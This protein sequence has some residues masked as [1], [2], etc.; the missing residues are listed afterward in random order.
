MKDSIVDRLLAKRI[1]TIDGEINGDKVIYIKK[2]L[3]NLLLQGSPPVKV[4]IS[5]NGGKVMAGLDIYDLLKL[6]SGK[7]TGVI[8]CEARS[9]AAVVL[10]A[11][12]YR[13]ATQNAGIMIHNTKGG[14]THDELMD[15]EKIKKLRQ[16]Y[17]D[18]QKR[19]NV[20]L[21][22]RTGKSIE[23]IKTQCAKEEDMSAHEAKEFGLIDGVWTKTLAEIPD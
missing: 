10:Q 7:K 8:V 21:S 5:S 6:Y 4:I 9:M 20:L 13:L 12:D 16:E 11:C 18:T 2:C 14:I 15:E 23:E 19:I 22:V 17:I 3:V 1:I